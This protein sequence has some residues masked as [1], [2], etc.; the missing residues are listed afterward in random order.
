M[1]VGYGYTVPVL[2]ASN[3]GS[4]ITKSRKTSSYFL[5]HGHC[6]NILP[7]I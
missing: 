7:V 3:L 4:N 2:S 6:E 1:I 5:E